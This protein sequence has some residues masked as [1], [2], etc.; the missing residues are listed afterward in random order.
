MNLG[1]IIYLLQGRLEQRGHCSTPT[2]N[3]HFM[4]PNETVSSEQAFI[5]R[6]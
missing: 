5:E 3:W 4:G 2:S 6:K 1:V